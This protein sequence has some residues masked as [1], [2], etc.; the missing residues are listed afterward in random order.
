M[1]IAALLSE[2]RPL[3]P[4]A[5]LKSTLV[6]AVETEASFSAQVANGRLTAGG[7]LTYAVTTFPQYKAQAPDDTTVTGVTCIDGSS[8]AGLVVGSCTVDITRIVMGITLLAQKVH[9]YLGDDAMTPIA[10]VGECTITPGIYPDNTESC[11]IVYAWSTFAVPVAATRYIGYPWAM[12]GRAMSTAG[13][14][15]VVDVGTP[16]TD[17]SEVTVKIADDDTRPDSVRTRIQ[18]RGC[19]DESNLLEYRLYGLT[20]QGVKTTALLA[21]VPKKN[22]LATP[23]VSGTAGMTATNRWSNTTYIE[24]RGGVPDLVDTSTIIKGPGRLTMEYMALETGFDRLNVGPMTFTG[25][26][27]LCI[28]RADEFHVQD[29]FCHN[30]LTGKTMPVS[31]E[32][33][34]AGDHT[35]RFITDVSGNSEGF[36]MRFE[37]DNHYE[38]DIE[39]GAGVTHVGVV[40]AY[41]TQ[42][43]LATAT[44]PMVALTDDGSGYQGSSNMGGL[45]RVV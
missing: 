5:V 7:V 30:L 35:V 18:F 41:R 31:D 22:F 24:W 16:D 32:L 13:W 6:T 23:P 27:S 36:T 37:R 14:G 20:E 43:K 44:T 12:N 10:K 4:P 45:Q 38:V 25:N 28:N 40:P 21:S 26:Y 33:L 2:F 29:G 17:V 15:Y 8:V 9:I 39:V 3:L 11:S 19:N 42:E 34:P 1:S